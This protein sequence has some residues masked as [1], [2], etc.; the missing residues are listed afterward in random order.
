M[1]GVRFSKPVLS[2][3]PRWT[4][5]IF[6]GINE[7]TRTRPR[8][9]KTKILKSYMHC[10]NLIEVTIT[11]ALLSGVYINVVPRLK[12]SVKERKA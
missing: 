4:N 11:D 8:K 9:V 10:N 5:L 2:V 3:N 7:V 6:H 1:L 12:T